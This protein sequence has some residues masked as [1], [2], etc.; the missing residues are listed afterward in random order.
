M[1]IV[2]I[3]RSALGN[4]GLGW[5]Q[6]LSAEANP[7][8][9]CAVRLD[10]LATGGDGVER[11]FIYEAPVCQERGIAV[12]PAL[13]GRLAGMTADGAG[14]SQHQNKFGTVMVMPISARDTI[15]DTA[16]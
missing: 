2:G 6:G 15:W 14:C 7:Q 3:S 11:L 8:I 10:L 5:E 16:T 13:I 1:E 12:Q 4:G 9:L